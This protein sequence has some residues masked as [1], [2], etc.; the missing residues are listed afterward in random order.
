MNLAEILN[1]VATIQVSGN[2]ETKEIELI[3]SNSINV[4]NNTL[5]TAIKGFKAD[6]HKFI[7]D[8]ISKGAQAV[9]LENDSELP[10]EFFTNLNVVKI[11]VADSRKALA[12]ISNSFFGDPSKKIKLIG[13]TGTKGKTTTTYYIKNVLDSAGFKSGLIGTNKN[14]VGDKIYPTKLT[15]PESNTINEL[16][17]EMVR[18]DCKYCV[19]EVSSHSLDLKRVY[20]LD[21]DSAV[22][23]NITSDHL[24]YHVNFKNYLSA[25][26]IL[27][28]ELKSDAE[29]IVNKDDKSWRELIKDSKADIAGYAFENDA[30]L[31]IKNVE[32]DLSGTS[33]EIEYDDKN[34]SVSTKLIGI[35]NA[36]NA[37]AA[38]AACVKLGIDTEK[39]IEGIKNTPQVP[40]RFEVFGAGDKK[41][42]VDYSHT[43]DSL[44]KALQA[45]HHIVKKERPIYTVFGCGGDRD[46][47]K[48]PV[49]G[50]IADEL[51]DK[52]VITSDNPRTEN[53]LLIIEDILKGVSGNKHI[54]QPDRE[55]AIKIAIQESEDNAVILIAG[56]GHEDYQEI[57]GVRSHFSDKETAEKYLFI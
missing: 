36:Y 4:Q 49:M 38:F 31:R 42:I 15:T 33:F 23:T 14:I 10:D 17:N 56:K 48:R 53:P 13:V 5:F 1:N 32:Y 41:V 9:V 6:G 50:K 57:N 12:E 55:E 45:V 21:F 11:L 54:V 35:F 34:Y 44:E 47:T 52:I 19:M 29:A 18:D 2:A 26:K 37:T 27:F 51:S 7:Q 28:D 8:A 40:G 24:D 25:K 3:T 16:M 46:K 30:E 22:F 20:G 39:I 43:A